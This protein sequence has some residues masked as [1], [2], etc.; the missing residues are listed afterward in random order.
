MSTEF[1]PAA[2]PADRVNYQKLPVVKDTYL[3]YVVAI[4]DPLNLHLDIYWPQELAERYSTA[5]HYDYTF[6]S[7]ELEKSIYTRPA[8]SCH[9]RGIE[10]LSTELHDSSNTKEAYILVSGHI[11]RAGGWILVSISDIDIYRRILV[12]VFEVISRKSI[13]QA[14]L[15]RVSGRSGH[16][17]ARE[18]ARPLRAKPAFSPTHQV[19]KDYHIVYGSSKEKKKK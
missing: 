16:K 4:R 13:N 15:D 3:A 17:I 7:E 14:L 2:S 6:V 1:S 12:N 11:I 5:L 8:Y 10:I 19:P 9:L 18:Y